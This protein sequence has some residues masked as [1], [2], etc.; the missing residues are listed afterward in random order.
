MKQDE[1]GPIQLNNRSI[2]A[3]HYVHHHAIGVGSDKATNR[4]GE[5][6]MNTVMTRAFHACMVATLATGLSACDRN[7]SAG[8]ADGG[9]APTTST[10]K[11]VAAGAPAAADTGAGRAAAGDSASRPADDGVKYGKVVNVNPVRETVNHPKQVCHNETVSH[12]TPPKDQH[13]ILGTAIG[14]VAGGLLG[15]QVGGGKGK[16]LATVAGAVG[17]GYAGNRVQASRQKGNVTTTVERRC[18]TVNESSTKVIGY[19]VRYVYNGVTRT[20]RMDRDPGDRVQV[21]EGVIAVSDAH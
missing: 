11:A 9:L 17:G 15:N 13:R 19:D 2:G 1:L 18:N 8:V 16:T 4:K 20:A 5:K 10:A 6:I 21:Q 3:R 12:T 14:A 7:A